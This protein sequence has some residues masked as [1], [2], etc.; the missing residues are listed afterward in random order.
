[1]D[2]ALAWESSGGLRALTGEGRMQAAVLIGLPIVVFCAMYVLNPSY[3]SLLIE[4]PWLLGT[5]LLTRLIPAGALMSRRR[6]SFL[7]PPAVTRRA[8]SCSA[9]WCSCDQSDGVKNHWPE[10]VPRKN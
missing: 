7:V 6:V 10:C 5:E 4:R 8:D 9:D 2:L 1:M 3:A